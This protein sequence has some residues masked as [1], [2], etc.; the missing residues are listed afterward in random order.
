MLRNV[1]FVTHTLTNRRKT[2]LLTDKKKKKTLI[3]WRNIQQSHCLFLCSGY[4]QPLLRFVKIKDIMTNHTPWFILTSHSLSVNK[5][6]KT[7]LMLWANCL[8]CHYAKLQ[9]T[10]YF[11]PAASL[12][13]IFSTPT[14]NSVKI[15]SQ[16]TII[17]SLLTSQRGVVKKASDQSQ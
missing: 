8:R 10:F 12:N 2:V 9:P 15:N 5:V 3:E 1:S 6:N 11:S 4:I 13:I 7:R 16:V 17:S 14:N